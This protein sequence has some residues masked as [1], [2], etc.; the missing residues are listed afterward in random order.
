MM[1]NTPRSFIGSVA[2]ALHG[3][4]R[5][6]LRDTVHAEILRLPGISFC[7]LDAAAGTL[8]VTAGAPVDRTSVVEVLDRLGCRVRA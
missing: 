5:A 4:V 6:Q 8:L 2:F 3:P 1:P 7:E